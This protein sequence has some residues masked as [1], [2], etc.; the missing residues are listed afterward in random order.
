MTDVSRSFK[1]EIARL[2]S[3]NAAV[4]V[5]EAELAGKKANVHTLKESLRDRI[6]A[7]QTS[8]CRVTDLVIQFMDDIGQDMID[9]FEAFEQRLKGKLGQLVALRYS[10]S[11]VTSYGSTTVE[12]IQT[13]AV[14][15]GVLQHETLQVV[16]REEVLWRLTLGCSPCVLLC[17]S[18]SSTL[19]RPHVP[20]VPLFGN[21]FG[22]YDI[23]PSCWIGE[24][25]KRAP[26]T[27]H[28]WDL[29]IGDEEVAAFLRERAADSVTLMN[30]VRAAL[31]QLILT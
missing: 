3:L 18:F 1:D 8:G 17:E 4:A 11:I 9:K 5:A 24:Y 23:A 27:H 28:P 29:L 22:D 20:K 21:T 6:K 16:P 31:G 13:N 12:R 7:G 25:I 30:S 19:M 10:T 14:R 2:E 26:D 15:I